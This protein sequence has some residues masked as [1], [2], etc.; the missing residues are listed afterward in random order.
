MES[1]TPAMRRP[2]EFSGPASGIRDLLQGA[3]GLAVLP[4]R[5]G[6]SR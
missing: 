4:Q 6:E 1:I 5:D 3:K 2:V